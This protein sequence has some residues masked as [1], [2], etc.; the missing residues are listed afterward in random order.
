MAAEKHDFMTMDQ[1]AKYLKIST[2]TLYKL[3]GEN[4]LLGQKIGKRWRFHRDAV[5][6]WLKTSPQTK[7]DRSRRM[8]AVKL[9][10]VTNSSGAPRPIVASGG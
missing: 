4:R 3:A 7:A 10:R 6:Q 1:L 8:S 2:S 9:F 5:D